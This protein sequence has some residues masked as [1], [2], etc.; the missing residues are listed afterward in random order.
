MCRP[1][2][3]WPRELGV[4]LFEK[5]RRGYEPSETARALAEQAERAE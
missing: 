1:V 4:A 3:P 5:S 2:R